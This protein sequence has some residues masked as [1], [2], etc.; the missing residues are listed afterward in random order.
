[1]PV[2]W[3]ALTT[4]APRFGPCRA[5]EEDRGPD[6]TAVKPCSRG[7]PTPLTVKRKAFW[8][9]YGQSGILAHVSQGFAGEGEGRT[10]KFDRYLGSPALSV[11]VEQDE[12]RELIEREGSSGPVPRLLPV[13]DRG[14]AR[15][16]QRAGSGNLD[17]GDEWSFC[18]TAARMAAGRERR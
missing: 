18:L 12:N 16:R 4:L 3:P 15:S 6:P 5:S 2:P 9:K 14:G 1:M 17:R 11:Q 10:C 7:S 8:P 13:R